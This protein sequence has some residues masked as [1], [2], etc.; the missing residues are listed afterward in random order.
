MDQESLQHHKS[1]SLSSHP[2][3]KPTIK[4]GPREG[5]TVFHNYILVSVIGE[6]SFGKVYLARHKDTNKLYAV[7][8]ENRGDPGSKVQNTLVNESRVLCDIK[9]EEGFPR[10][11][12]F[13]KDS[14]RATM[15]MTLLGQN[16]EQLFDFCKGKFS[17]NTILKI[18][19][20]T[21]TR[22]RQL[23]AHGYIHR[24]L[25]PENFLI[26]VE[27][28]IEKIHLIDF[29]FATKYLKENGEHIPYAERCG[30]IGTARYTSLNSHLGIQQSRRDDL[31]SLGYLLIYLAK[32][33]LPWNNLKALSKDEKNKLILQVLHKIYDIKIFQLGKTLGNYP[34]I[35]FTKHPLF[36][37]QIH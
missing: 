21:L 6:G 3:K 25:K 27:K 12:Y 31:E 35:L 9:G 37:I 17:M 26:G 19:E 36:P 24:D 8:I 34:L 5:S 30:Q 2:N 28:N 13:I 7:K 23:H 4:L 15:V 32:G 18:A 14:M 29:G 11:N 1:R 22:V 16:L 33:D 20:Q 10:M